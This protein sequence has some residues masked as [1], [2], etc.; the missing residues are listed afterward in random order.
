M[1]QHP[2]TPQYSSS[3]QNQEMKSKQNIYSL[4]VEKSRNS[5][6]E[7]PQDISMTLIKQK[8]SQNEL[9]AFDTSIRQ[10]ISPNETKI[11]L[12]ND[13]SNLIANNTEDAQLNVQ[14]QGCLF[15][16][17]IDNVIPICR[18]S[19]AHLKCANNFLKSGPIL[20]QLKCQKCHDFRQVN[21]QVSFDF[22]LWKSSK[23]QLLIEI[24]FLLLIFSI[25]GVLI[26]FTTIL[27]QDSS[28]NDRIIISCLVFSYTISFIVLLCIISK[29]VGHFKKIRFTIKQYDPLYCKINQTYINLMQEQ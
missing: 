10:K 17:E 6:I 18:C 22:N 19:Q 24:I 25:I 20:E 13:Q 11:L 3:N 9:S 29:I 8:P 26:F 23:W 12:N 15:C 2:K 7:Q 14:L 1:I 28:A 16:N 5:L 4:K 27:V 21:S